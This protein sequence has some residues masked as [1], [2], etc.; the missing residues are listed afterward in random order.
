[1]VKN[2]KTQFECFLFVC[3]MHFGLVYFAE[4]IVLPVI[5]NANE[6]ENFRRNCVRVAPTEKYKMIPVS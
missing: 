4:N 5:N 2:K 6:N 1:M 3:K